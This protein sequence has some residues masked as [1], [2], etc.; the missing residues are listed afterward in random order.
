M[1]LTISSTPPGLETSRVCTGLSGRTELK[2]SAQSALDARGSQLT[3]KVTTQNKHAHQ[4]LNGEYKPRIQ[5]VL[6]AS[7]VV[8]RMVMDALILR[9]DPLPAV[10]PGSM[11]M[12]QNQYILTEIAVPSDE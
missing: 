11:A 1:A 4:P 8:D 5:A 12:D 6:T 3:T 9:H 10:T 2:T 7:P